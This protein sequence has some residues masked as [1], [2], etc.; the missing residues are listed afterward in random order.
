MDGI[1]RKCVFPNNCFSVLGTPYSD[2]RV[3]GPQ[4]IPGTVWFAYYDVGGPEISFHINDTQNE[5]SCRLNPCQCNAPHTLCTGT[6]RDTFRYKDP[7]STS[8]TK[9][10]VNAG[11]CCDRFLKPDGTF[12]QMPINELYVGWSNPGNWFTYTVNVLL[13]GEYVVAYMGTANL[14]G[15]MGME[16]DF[17]DVTKNLTIAKTGYYHNWSYHPALFTVQL[18]A[19]KHVLKWKIVANADG[20]N[21]GNFNIGWIDFQLTGQ[22]NIGDFSIVPN[23]SV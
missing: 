5:G 18:T 23:D 3:D 1:I 8:Y 19:G 4:T 20:S 10:G 2:D 17:M 6:Y 12:V 14:G 21:D 9:N 13:T 22:S 16:V 7:V 15:W 11:F